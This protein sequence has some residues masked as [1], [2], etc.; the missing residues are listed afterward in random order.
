MKDAGV[1][2]A[3]GAENHGLEFLGWG[4][5]SSRLRQFVFE[6]S[7]LKTRVFQHPEHTEIFSALK[8]R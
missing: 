4:F 6:A 3:R 1:A 7:P 2:S 5:E 8:P